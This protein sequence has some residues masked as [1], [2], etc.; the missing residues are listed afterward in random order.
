M[1]VLRLFLEGDDVVGI[2]TADFVKVSA[3]VSYSVT[4]LAE[5]EEKWFNHENYIQVM[6]EHLRSLVRSRCRTQSLSELFHLTCSRADCSLTSS[7][8]LGSTQLRPIK[9]LSFHTLKPLP[10]PIDLFS[11][12]ADLRSAF[13]IPASLFQF[14]FR[15]N[16]IGFNA[17]HRRT[18][19]NP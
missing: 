1:I 4:F 10:K 14:H 17:C 12:F 18:I 6:C 16:P 8:P 7:I 3:R 13:F 2:E 9:P 11:K 15:C 5:H 19:A